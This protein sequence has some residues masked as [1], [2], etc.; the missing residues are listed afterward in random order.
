MRYKLIP[1]H[2]KGNP[3]N[4][5]P[6]PEIPINTNPVPKKED[7]KIEILGIRPI[8]GFI[9]WPRGNTKGYFNMNPYKK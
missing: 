9:T 5:N 2:A 3:I 6:L 4:T 8:P 1:K 7:K